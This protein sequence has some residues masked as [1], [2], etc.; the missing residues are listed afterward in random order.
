MVLPT[1]RADGRRRVRR[2]RTTHGTLT[3]AREKVVQFGALGSKHS[4]CLPIE[5]VRRAFGSVKHPFQ[6]STNGRESGLQQAE[7]VPGESVE[8]H[9]SHKGPLR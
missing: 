3:D 2:R 1:R 7:G 9:P 5:G 8:V 6:V 4:T